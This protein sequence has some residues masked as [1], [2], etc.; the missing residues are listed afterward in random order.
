MRNKFTNVLMALTVVA[1]GIFAT[2][3]AD[4]AKRKVVIE[5]HTGAWCQFCPMGIVEFQKLE[6]QY[7]DSFIG[8][9]VHNGDGMTISP[10][11]GD[12]ASE[13]G[14]NAYPN[15]TIN[16]KILANAKQAQH[17]TSPDNSNTP[18]LSG[19]ASM[20]NQQVPVGVSVAVDYDKVT[21]DYT[22]TVTAVVESALNYPLAFNLW[23]LEEYM[24]GTGQQ[25]DQI[26][27]LSGNPAYAGTDFYSLP[28]RI[29]GYIHNEVFRG[30]TGGLWGSTEGLPSG[31]STPAGTY[32]KTYTG[33]V[34]ALN[35]ENSLNAYFVAIVTNANTKEIIN[36]DRVG[37]PNYTKEAMAPTLTVTQSEIYKF[38]PNNESKVFKVGV[39]NN[40]NV[41]S[42][43]NISISS[44][45]VIPAGWD[46]QV[47]PVTLAANATGEFEISVNPNNNP[48]LAIISFRAFSQ[49]PDSKNWASQ[50]NVLSLSEA[51]KRMF[52][53]SSDQYAGVM[54]QVLGFTG[55]FDGYAR[56]P[57]SPSQLEAFEPNLKNIL[58]TAIFTI[59]EGK[60]GFAAQVTAANLTTIKNLMAGG[61][62]IL[63]SAP[64][65][66]L[67]YGNAIPNF[68][69]TGDATNFFK[70]TLGV[71]LGLNLG[72]V[73]DQNQYIAM[74]VT[75]VLNDPISNG[76]AF[77]INQ[78]GVVRP[79]QSVPTMILNGNS[80]A[81]AF[82]EAPNSAP[83][84]SSN[85]K[86]GIK[87]DNKG[88]RTIFLS[89]PT[90]ASQNN[91][92][93]PYV[94][95]MIVWLEG[96]DVVQAD[97][98]KIAL[99]VKSLKFGDVKV[100]EKSTKTVTVSNTGDEKLTITSANLKSGTIFSVKTG[101]LPISIDAGQTVTFTV[102]FTPPSEKAFSDELTIVS[103][104]PGQLSSVVTMNGLGV[105][106]T[107]SVPG[108]I[109]DLFE[110]TV[111][112]NPIVD[113]SVINFN[114]K[115]SANVSI[116]LIDATG[117][118]I[119]Q[120][121]NGVTTGSNVDLNAAQ[122]SSGTYYINANVDGKNTQIPVVITK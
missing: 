76:I 8:V 98:P 65:D 85:N 50:N 103:N 23:A 100:S 106:G 114:V 120:L 62:D 45:S 67:I 86:L 49:V 6:K 87:L 41:E 117:R 89:L 104:D 70:N 24:R 102:E 64:A 66:L 68:P 40:N 121:F 51:T 52:F 116:E 60:T 15:G 1:T 27:A 80:N 90:D 44:G 18:W 112:P 7:G 29:E 119:N 58:N 19:V 30:A 71:D 83:L 95:N 25:W 43:H 26:N 32:T 2:Q 55:S 72:L 115:K 84:T 82:L 91:I 88:Q 4:A 28:T 81:T 35:V 12:L 47:N 92:I 63:L 53:E 38:V 54:N 75:G 69:P 37:R 109:S 93:V 78:Q 3:S 21:G 118:V 74:P 39:K 108:V 97:G 46:V 5:D 17:P 36:A 14:V 122:L 113:N 13:M 61:V 16:R 57:I 11:Q 48:G 42:V 34:K 96:E 110:M 99:S 22:A 9:A 56:S 10:Y 79:I 107:T 94:K 73:N 31:G 105:N 20:I 33:N 111:T 77:N 59:D 101:K